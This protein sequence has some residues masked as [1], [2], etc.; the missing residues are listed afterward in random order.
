MDW[1]NYRAALFDL[2]GVLTPTTDIHMRAW[3][4]MFNA[5]LAGR[6]DEEP[7]T[8]DDYFAYVDGKP[9]YE[10][11]ASFLASRGIQLEYGEPDDAPTTETVAG[12]GN[13]KNQVFNQVLAEDG[14]APYPGSMA[15]IE[16]LR[17]AGVPMA[18][19]SS[20]RNAPAVLTAAGLTEFFGTVI[21]G[22]AAAELGLP[23][24]PKPDTFLHAA[25]QLQVAP[26]ECVVLEDA[27][28]GVEAARAGGFGLVVGVD[29]GAG[30][31]ELASAGANLVIA[32]CAELL[33]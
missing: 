27:L 14:I 3:T 23:G 6:G 26:E 16:A 13:R 1:N 11:V 5:F 31:D 25:W 18:V 7:F 19:V 33:P 10:G 32:D 12:L 17:T 8:D 20:S 29:R 24:K 21:D 4:Q 15:L 22:N 9:R 28:S 30:A 2:D